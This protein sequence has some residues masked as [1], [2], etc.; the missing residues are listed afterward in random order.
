MSWSRGEKA[1]EIKPIDLQS[2]QT[3]GTAD[4]RPSTVHDGVSL[5]FGLAGAI[6][7]DS[8]AALLILRCNGIS[9]VFLQFYR[10]KR[11]LK[12]TELASSQYNW[13]SGAFVFGFLHHFFMK[14]PKKCLHI[15][16]FPFRFIRI[17]LKPF[18]L[19]RDK[20]SVANTRW[21]RRKIK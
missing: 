2:V 21:K 20:G 13:S 12:C 16:Q 3:V 10:K 5:Y 9:V 17:L 15:L 11:V 4:G 7:A 6:S 1:F 19:P 8:I 14:L 18:D